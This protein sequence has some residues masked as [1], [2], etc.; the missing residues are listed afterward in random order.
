[1][2]SLPADPGIHR[3]TRRLL[4]SE[5]DCGITDIVGHRPGPR[6]CVLAGMHVNEV[7][8]IEAALQLE[9]SFDPA[10]LAGTVSVIS[11]LNTPAWKERSIGI[12]P[13]DSK[14]INFCFPGDPSGSFSERLAHDLLT[15]WSADAACVVD[16]HGGDLGEDLMRYSICQMTGDSAFDRRALALARCFD[17]EVVVALEPSYM[18]TAGRSVTALAR[19]RRFGGFAEAGRGGILAPEDVAM[20][21]DGVLRVAELLEM[22]T[23]TTELVRALPTAPRLL[24]GYAWVPI[25]VTGWATVHVAAGAVVEQGQRIATVVS[26]SD[27]NRTGIDAPES[28]V[29]LWCDTHPAVS[30]G[31]HIAG[32]GFAGTQ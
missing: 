8:S 18:A 32:I 22:T 9:R 14:N 6:L 30:E 16:L 4:D 20:H 17:V 11:V 3:S 21:R 7:S 29:I 5:F 31:A 12:C 27:G 24:T 23:A 2:T 13:V 28:G 10:R 15:D 19:T 26:L 1:M 25:P